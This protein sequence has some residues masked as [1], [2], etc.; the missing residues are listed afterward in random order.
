LHT[1]KKRL[2]GGSL[3]ERARQGFANLTEDAKQKV[4]KSTTEKLIKKSGVTSELSPQNLRRYC[5]F[6]SDQISA[7]KL[8]VSGRA[9][10]KI[11][12]NVM[13]NIGLDLEDN[14]KSGKSIEDMTKF[15]WGEEKFQKLWEKLGLSFD[16]FK[17]IID[18]AF[19]KSQ[20]KGVT[21]G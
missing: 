3:F 16:N 21:N 13:T 15:F 18:G 8:D 5:S 1:N 7:S 20:G 17:I 11:R 2:P 6:V 19:E 9:L 4:V 10:G 14:F 12:E